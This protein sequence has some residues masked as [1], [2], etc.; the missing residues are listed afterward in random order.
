MCRVFAVSLA[1]AAASTGNAAIVLSGDFNTG[2][3]TPM[4]TITEDIVFTISTGGSVYALVFDEWAVSDGSTRTL[5]ASPDQF[6]A[7]S[8]NGIGGNTDISSITDNYWGGGATLTAND[9][10]LFFAGIAFATDDTFTVKAG[11]YTFGAFPGFN[12]ALAGKHFT[13]EVF[14]TNG[15]G[16]RLSANVSLVPEP[17]ALMLSALGMLA[18]LRRRR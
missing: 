16:D 11:S 14:L 8:L 5:G 12:P 7:Y 15:D 13:G 17:S 1:L 18:V 4:L 3:P 6:F 2:S 10:Y 9:G